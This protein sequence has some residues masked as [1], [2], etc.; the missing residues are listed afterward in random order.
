MRKR[1][2]FLM[3]FT[4][5][6]LAFIM[7][8]SFRVY[9]RVEQPVGPPDV[10]FIKEYPIPLA[11][12]SPFKIVV[13]T[14]GPPASVW[15]TLPDANAIGHMTITDTTDFVFEEH[16]IPTPNS[17]PYDLAYDG[18][19]YLWFTE[20]DGNKIG[21]LNIS[22]HAIDEYNVPTAN[23][24]PSGIDIAPN[25]RIWFLERDGNKLGQFNPSTGQF[26]AEYAYNRSNAQ[27][28][29]I[30]VRSDTSIWFTS[31]THNLV[32]EY[33]LS[34]G[35]FIDVAVIFRPG[36]PT[37]PPGDIMF[38]NTLLWVSAPEEDWIGVHF[39]GT[40]TFWRPVSML[41]S[42]GGPTGL[43]YSSPDSLMHIWFV[44]TEGGR[45]GKF[46]TNS[47]GVISYHWSEPLPTQNSQPRN[48]AVA[49]N[50]HAWITEMGANKIAEWRPPTEFYKI[51]LPP[52]FKP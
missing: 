13:E 24:K 22:T 42:G 2:L 45:V 52:I 17:K 9:G 46:V 32:S 16:P 20:Q 4:N 33:R 39:P 51:Y 37:T 11:N 34:T 14:S 23:S 47:Q 10:G 18:S 30:A 31:L 26:V 1:A 3:G 15:F 38:G 49:D 50:E 8:T 6:L 40:L 48:I 28:E 41:F 25:G 27:L 5:L 36:N 19:T 43:A 44:E 7:L 35:M 29:D 12:G 21:R